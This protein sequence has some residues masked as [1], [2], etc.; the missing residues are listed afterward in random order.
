MW[1]IYEDLAFQNLIECKDSVSPATDFLSFQWIPLLPLV[2]SRRG[3]LEILG[4]VITQWLAG[5]LPWEHK[6][7]EAYTDFPYV[8]NQKK[9]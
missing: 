8:M 9:Q 6:I 5:S 7:S 1:P 2:P 4:Y 3:D